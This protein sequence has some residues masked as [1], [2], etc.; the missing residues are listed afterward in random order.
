MAWVIWSFPFGMYL[1]ADNFLQRIPILLFFISMLIIVLSI[2]KQYA[3][4]HGGNESELLKVKSIGLSIFLSII[5]LGIYGM[6]WNYSIC[7]KIR[8][9]NHEST[10]CTGEWLCLEFIP[11]YGLYWV[12]TRS[13]KI[14]SGAA[15]RGISVADNSTVC[16]IVSI[17]GLGIIAFALI[18]NSLNEI[19]V[20]LTAPRNPSVPYMAQPQN[21]AYASPSAHTA[22][23]IEEIKQLSQ[24]HQQGI[25]TDQ[26][27]ENKKKELLSKI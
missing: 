2:E 21:V 25:L 15:A 16:L 27:F 26:E 10:E 24:L 13:K 4:G 8:L 11:Y 7:K 17:F 9:L 23:Y 20:N 5:T 3:A 12:Y 1:L 22:N 18:Q 19:A 6:V 14:S